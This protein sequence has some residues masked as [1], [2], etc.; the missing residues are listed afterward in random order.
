M[1]PSRQFYKTGEQVFIDRSFEDWEPGRSIICNNGSCNKV[2]H[3]L[4][5]IYESS[6]LYNYCPPPTCS[7]V[8]GV[9]LILF[10]IFR[11]GDLRSST[12]KLCCCPTCPLGTL[13]WRSEGCVRLHESGR[14][15]RSQ[16]TSSALKSTARTLTSSTEATRKNAW[17]LF[18]YYCVVLLKTPSVRTSNN[19]CCGAWKLAACFKHIT[20]RSCIKLA[21][22][23]C[24][25]PRSQLSLHDL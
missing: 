24:L 18:V 6:R 23:L 20:H 8:Y 17:K 7:E 21:Q 13:H 14:T 15:S 25:C 4:L 10:Y 9:L 16:L 11:C 3:L 2:Q 12:R 22:Q 5:T 19:S 1:L